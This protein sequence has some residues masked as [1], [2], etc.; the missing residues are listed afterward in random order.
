MFL[1]AKQHLPAL[2]PALLLAAALAL[3]PAAPAFAADLN[4][5]VRKI[6]EFGKLVLV[7]ILL[8]V[9]IKEFFGHNIVRAVIILLVG[10]VVYMVADENTLKALAE[11][12]KKLLNLQ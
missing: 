12:I 5:S 10:A 3:A 11:A 6:L 7:V 1:V 9:A 8:F 4:E 2:F